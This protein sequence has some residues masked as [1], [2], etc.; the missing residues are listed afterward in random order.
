MFSCLKWHLLLYFFS[1]VKQM[2]LHKYM[3]LQT[4][5]LLTQAGLRGSQAHV[6]V[7]WPL[8]VSSPS[9]CSKQILQVVQAVPRSVLKTSKNGSKPSVWVDTASPL[10]RCILRTVLSQQYF[11]IQQHTLRVLHLNLLCLLGQSVKSGSGCIMPVHILRYYQCV[12]S[13]AALC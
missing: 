10:Q 3:C 5:L 7:K 6:D 8:E 4:V 9:P 2:C 1:S 11:F 13:T 12:L